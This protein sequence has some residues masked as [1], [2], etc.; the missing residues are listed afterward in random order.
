MT[1]LGVF[2]FH[3]DLRYHDNTAFLLA[4]KECVKVLPV[5]IFDPAQIDPKKNPYFS[6]PALQFICESLAELPDVHLFKGKPVDILGKI[7]PHFPFTRVYQNEDYSVFA[8][9]R[10]AQLAAWCRSNGIEMVTTEDYGL[11]PLKDCLLPDGRPYAVMS[12][13]YKRCLKVATVRKPAPPSSQEKK[14]F[15]GRRPAE[16]DM[17]K[18]VS[19]PDIAQHGGRKEGLK[20]MQQRLLDYGDVRDFPALDKTSKLSAHIR[21]GT[22]SIREVYWAFRA[23]EP[24]VRELFFREFYL[25]IYALRPEL[26]R[27]VAFNR[28]V[29][30]RIPWRTKF[31]EEWQAGTTGFP[32][33]DAGMRQ[34]S[35]TNWCH[36]RVRMIVASVA[37]KYFLLDWRECAR[38]FYTQ[39][40]DADTFSNTAGWGW[41]SSTGVDA[42]PY[43]RAPFNPFLQSAKFDKDAEYIKKYVPELMDVPAKDIHKWYLPEV[44]AKYPSVSYPAPVVDYKEASARAVK[45]FTS[46]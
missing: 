28:E 12:S 29:D 15:K 31:M 39:L 2:I 24:F 16:V 8:R 18:Y 45:V 26:Q 9:E 21:F 23:V 19:N 32:I 22:V 38:Y 40:V 25:K 30:A 11:L 14:I 41:S 1:T 42:V 27:G 6:A 34:L 13:F 4:L 7:R 36:N 20:L 44:R 37:T 17:I 33:A 35:K 10:D 43:F 3:R 5:F 46:S